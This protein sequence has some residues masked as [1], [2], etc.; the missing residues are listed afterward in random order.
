MQYGVLRSEVQDDP[1]GRGY[2]NMTDAEV[3]SSLNTEDRTV[4]DYTFT[5]AQ[6]VETIDPSEL[7]GA[8]ST[9]RELIKIVAG[10][11]GTVDLSSGTN[12]RALIED[13]FGSNST[14]VGNIDGEAEETV[15]RATEIGI[16]EEVKPY[17]VAKVRS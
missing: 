12:V 15:S 6:L 7:K 17:H 3:A 4:Q 14:T 2:S 10:S 1:L 8:S 13:V 11:D 5:T 9:V 16:A